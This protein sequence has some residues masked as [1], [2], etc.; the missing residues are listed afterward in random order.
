MHAFSSSMQSD[1]DIRLRAAI[2]AGCRVV[3]AEVALL[4]VVWLF[5]LATVPTHA[6]WVREVWGGASWPVIEEVTLIAIAAFKICVWLQAAL[7]LWAV[8]WAS[9]MRRT[10]SNPATPPE[11][12]VSR[13]SA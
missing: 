8:L 11:L 6:A 2:S 12:T 3:L 5:Y 10:L 4:V 7:L 13:S 9:A 1:F